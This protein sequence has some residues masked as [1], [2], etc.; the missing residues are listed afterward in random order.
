M[1]RYQKRK[2]GPRD[3]HNKSAHARSTPPKHA[4]KYQL[5][6]LVKSNGIACLDVLDLVEEEVQDEL[7]GE[8]WV[9]R[10]SDRLRAT[11]LSENITPRTAVMVTTLRRDRRLVGG[12]CRQ[13][14][15]SLLIP[16]LGLAHG[17]VLR[18]RSRR[19]RQRHLLGDGRDGMVN[20]GH[21]CQENILRLQIDIYRPARGGGGGRQQ[22]LRFFR[23]LAT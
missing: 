8:L 13:W 14:C 21:T 23:S 9:R 6:T 4:L 16:G 17:P 19:R 22:D 10:V 2:P 12:C 20:A 18:G 5:A 1:T 11:D 3:T 15:S 7:L